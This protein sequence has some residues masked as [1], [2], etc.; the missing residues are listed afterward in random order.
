MKILKIDKKTNELEIIPDSFDDLWHIE[1]II[2]EGDLVSGDSERK[3]KPKTEGEKAF[4]QKIFVEIEVTKKEFHEATNQL[5]IQGVV[6]FAKP[7]ELVEL[8]SHHTIEIEVGSK[9]TIKK[10]ELKNYEIER[11]KRAK[12]ASGRAKLL[13]VVMDDE[14]AEI[15]FLADTGIKRKAKILAKKNGKQYEKNDN[16]NKYF[17]EL[18]KKILEL[19]PE[20][21]IIAGPGFEK[22]NFEK[23]LK[24]NH[25]KLQVIFDS[26][27]SVGIT[28]LNELVKSGKID[29]LVEGFHSAEEAKAIEKL[30]IGL[31]NGKSAVG[32]IETTQALNS[33]A[34]EELIILEKA[35]VEKREE[36]NPLI[37]LAENTRT[38]IIFVSDKNEAG[39]K[40]KG[41]GE[42]AAILRYKLNY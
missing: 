10:K 23:Y 18:L 36:L 35:L 22:Q 12:E 20:K 4:K 31:S 13:M 30:L 41:L 38:K 29:K 26:T 19:K 3:I 33:G 34:V 24:E 37:D 42:V 16:E 40:L 17:E 7:E 6:V 11:L 27:N 15:A 5:R 9:I 2:T 8:K 28:G 39:E 21:I 1:K 14:E 32:I 25:Q